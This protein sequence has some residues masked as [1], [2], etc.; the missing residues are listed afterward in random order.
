MKGKL[1]LLIIV[2]ISLNCISQHKYKTFTAHKSIIDAIRIN[3][4]II[5]GRTTFFEKQAEVKPL[6]F[7]KTKVRISELNRLSNN[8]SKY[9]ESIQEEV[10]TEMILYE[11]LEKDKYKTTLFKNNGNLT[12]KGKKLKDKIDSLYNCSVKINVHQLS[13]LENFYND[14]FKTSAR[15]YEYEKE[16]NYFEYLFYDKSNYGM[17]MAMNC[18]LLDVKTFQLLYYGTVMSY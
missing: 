4:E 18:L 15:Y 2:F 1:V 8:L 16:I 5:K 6:M 17:M 10:N 7:Q 13:Q 9:I 3:D 12:L 11:L 14:N